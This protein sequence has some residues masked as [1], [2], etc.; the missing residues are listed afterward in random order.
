[1]NLRERIAA[2][3][4][5][6]IFGRPER[7][8]LRPVLARALPGLAV[9]LAGSLTAALIAL[10][11]PWITKLLIDRG[12]IGQDWQMVPRYAGLGFAAG[13]LIL[14]ASVGN[15]LLH[16]RFSARM[17]ADLRARM[18][19]AALNRRADL[20]PLTI[21]ETM[22]RVDGDTAEIQR[23]AF[24]TVLAAAGSMFR[25]IG[26]T[27]MLIV[28]DWRLALIPLM[29]A[30]FNLAFLTWARPRTRQRADDLRVNRGALSSYLAE[31][32]AGLPNLRSLGAQG[33]RVDGFAPLQARQI[34]LLMRQRRWSEFA[35]AVPQFS[36]AMARLLVLMGGGWLIVDGQWQVG[37]LIAFLSYMGLMT[38]PLQNLLGLYHA[39]AT[40]QVA[41]A[42]LDALAGAA[43]DQPGRTPS[44]GPGALRL[45]QARGRN[46]THA[47]VDLTI[48]PGETVLIDGPSG[49]GK[50]TL[51]GLAGRL[52]APA[53][54]SRVFLDGEDTTGLD[55]TAL[56]RTIAVIPQTPML[57]RGTI[58]DN[59][60][61]ADP[62]AGADV[63]AEMLDIAGLDLSLDA[64]IDEAGRSLSGGE[65]Q[66]IALARALLLPFRVLVLDECLSEVDAPTASQILS[67]IRCRF[68]D[69]TLI[70][71]AH[72][73]PARAL[74]FDQ[75]VPLAP[76]PALLR[77]LR[78]DMPNQRENARENAV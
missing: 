31:G 33:L 65:R 29:A 70:V 17:L 42:R 68:P 16:L 73:G 53:S 27:V 8:W 44:D 26:G 56:R 36:A 30:P 58:A 52:S 32:F 43:E 67:A 47:A 46:S 40:A 60:R 28:L 66:R 4:L 71:I 41:L 14:L 25:L 50:S 78:G 9:V 7:P 37:A 12:L 49:I 77:S 61:L 39:Q 3:L 74:A 18:L 23:F 24:D 75:V 6:L 5:R 22:A 35:S 11:P 34:A 1:M 10:L 54:G 15:S 63:M 21:G 69:R 55:P 76:D 48:R 45:V 38:G 57:F 72:A 64:L 13:A 19:E 20:P 62:L 51:M 59:L 2:L